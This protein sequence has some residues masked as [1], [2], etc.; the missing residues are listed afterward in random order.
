[1]PRLDFIG[2]SADF[3]GGSKLVLGVCFGVFF[4]RVSGWRFGASFQTF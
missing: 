3:W 4:R 2:G 1:V